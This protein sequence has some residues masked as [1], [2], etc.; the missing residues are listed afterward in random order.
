MRGK[1]C[2]VFLLAAIAVVLGI[3]PRRAGAGDLKI[4]L[5]R[6][7]QP[8]PVQQLNQDGVKAIGKQQY[9]KA[10]SLFYKAYLYDPSDPFTLYN[11]GYICELEGQLERAQRFYALASQQATDATIA[12][13]DS[14][15]LEGR[16]MR[17]ALRG[18]WDAPMQTNR[19]NVEAIRLL[20]QGRAPEA[21]MLLRQTLETDPHNAFT[22]NDLG[23][24][25]EAEGKWEEALKYYAAAA[26][27][28][29]AEPVVVS[30]NGG[31]RNKPVSEMAA[32]SEK[33]LRQR[34]SSRETAQARAARL[35]LRGVSAVNR[36]DWQE[37]EQ[38]FRQAYAL[39]PSSAFSLNNIGFV[40]ERNGDLETA[41]FFYEKARR[42]ADANLRVSLATRHSAEGMPLFAVADDS[43]QKVDTK[44]AAESAIRRSRA[45][46][47]QL[48][49]RD[50]KPVVPPQP[51][52]S[53]ETP[54]SVPRPPQQDSPPPASL[55]Q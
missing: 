12:R 2:I 54:Q 26:N 29:S 6:R 21:E 50:G 7:S 27:S 23:V 51:A 39:D 18:L 53:P 34:M 16:P 30:L 4:V 37:A 19:A 24:A 28:H 10:E 43:D 45:G 38:D 41:Q 55:P 40:A 11:L 33:I 48:K 46:P 13:A 3:A 32:Q 47:I 49:R 36:N 31:W 1:Q 15:A 25:L 42:A 17:D 14:S 9:Q 52:S 20:S 35:G 44:M 8:T 22:L 5:P